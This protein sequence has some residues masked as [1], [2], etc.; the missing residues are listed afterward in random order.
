MTFLTNELF[1]KND[2]FL[3]NENVNIPMKPSHIVV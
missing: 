1:Q 3:K 2:R